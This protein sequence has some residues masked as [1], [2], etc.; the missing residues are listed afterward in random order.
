MRKQRVLKSS[1]ERSGSKGRR[2]SRDEARQGESLVGTY[3]EE[4]RYGNMF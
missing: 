4:F 3:F 1:L 2:E